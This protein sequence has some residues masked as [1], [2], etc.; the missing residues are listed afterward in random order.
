MVSGRERHASG[1]ASHRGHGGHRGGIELGGGRAS[2]GKHGFWAGKTHQGRASHRGHGGHKGGLRLEAE[3]F[4]WRAWFLGGKHAS[5]RASHRGH[6]GHRGGLRLEGEGLLVDSMVS[7]RE[8]RIGESITQRA[9]RSQRGIELGGG[10]A[11]GG[12]HGFWAGRHASGRASHRGHGGHKG[13]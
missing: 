9:R 4:W 2:G 13:D 7:G 11:F 1:R 5:G 12:K 8:T 10:R 3:G 6:G